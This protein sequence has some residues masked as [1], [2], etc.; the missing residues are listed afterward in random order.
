MAILRGGRRIGPFD[1]RLGLP[2]DRSLEN[3]EGDKRLKDPLGVQRASTIGAFVSEMAQGEGFARPN[4]F[5]VR[6]YLPS[7]MKLGIFG[8]EKNE[9]G[10][11]PQQTFDPY[12]SAEMQKNVGLMCSKVTIPSRDVNTTENIIYG[13][14]RKMPYGYSYSGELETTFYGDKFLRQRL[15]F[16]QWQE[17]I[18]STQ[19]HNLNFYN[20]YVGTMDIYQLGQFATEN[21]RES[22]TYGVRLHEVYPQTIGSIDYAYGEEGIVNVP[23][24]LN[25]RNWESLTADQIGKSSIGTPLGQLPSVVPSKDFGF[26]DSILNKLPPEMKRAGRNVVNTVRRNLPIGE[27]TGGRVFP[28]FI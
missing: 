28:P 23:I 5:L 13:P 11:P 12:S 19:T 14:G 21:D 24:T 15:F 22:V 3:I 4:R 2:R 10:P 27:I 20:D 18:F 6:F 9:V 17:K 16:E 8:M 26:L 1:I 7:K 25:F